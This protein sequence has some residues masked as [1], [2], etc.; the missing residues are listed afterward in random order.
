VAVAV[1]DYGM[2]GILLSGQ[3]QQGFIETV[4]AELVEV[5]KWAEARLGGD[6][7]VC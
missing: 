2:S 7:E 1:S 6:G 5:A 3:C 4:G